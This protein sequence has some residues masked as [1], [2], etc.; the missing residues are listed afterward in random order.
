MSF[1]TLTVFTRLF[2]CFIF[3]T[4]YTI[5]I[6]LLCVDFTDFLKL[7][8]MDAEHVKFWSVLFKNCT[9]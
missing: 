8:K 2:I 1:L 6:F 9:C 7:L 4:F 3:I 5:S